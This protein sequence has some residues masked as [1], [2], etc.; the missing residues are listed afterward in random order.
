MIEIRP[1][2][3]A[4]L[5]AIQDIFLA[6]MAAGETYTFPPTLSTPEIEAVWM[7]PG[8]SPYVAC[9]EGT[10][11]GSYTFHANHPGRGGHVANAS[12][13]VSEKARGKGVGRKLGEHSLVTAKAQGFQAMQFNIVVSTNTAAV[14]LWQSLG[15]N[16]IGT[17]PQAFQH[18]TLGLVDTYIMHR[19]L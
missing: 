3:S 17:V 19:F 5:P 2:T 11:L 4:D 7:G 6:I 10:V 15:F 9:E 14:S 13:I 18:P 12:Y 1:A 8:F 16:I